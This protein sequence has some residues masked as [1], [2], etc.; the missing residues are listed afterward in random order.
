[1]VADYIVT[2]ASVQYD[3]TMVKIVLVEDDVM[4]AELYQTR[5]QLAGYECVVANDGITGL[6]A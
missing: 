3:N 2:I 4:L 5:L 1:M 6:Q